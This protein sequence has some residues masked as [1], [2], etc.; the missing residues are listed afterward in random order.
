MVHMRH[1]ER[2]SQEELQDIVFSDT[3]SCNSDISHSVEQLR[4][5]ERGCSNKEQ[6]VTFTLTSDDEEVAC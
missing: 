5:G 4:D 3:R 2:I 6:N 1:R